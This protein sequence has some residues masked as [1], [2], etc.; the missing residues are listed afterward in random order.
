MADESK[1]GMFQNRRLILTI[2]VILVSAVVAW[3]EMHAWFVFRYQD[4]LQTQIDVSDTV[5]SGH[6]QWRAFQGRILIPA[7]I[8]FLQ[9]H[10]ANPATVLKL[11]YLA[12]LAILFAANLVL[13][14]FM[15]RL[16]A[17]FH[18]IVS[19][20]IFSSVF[21]ASNNNIFTYPW[22]FG[23]FILFSI[24]TSF[25]FKDRLN[26]V[27][28]A[29]FIVCLFN[30]ESSILFGFFIVAGCV[31]TYLWERKIE[32]R[33]LAIGLLMLVIAVVVTELLRRTLFA[34][35][36]ADTEHKL[37]ENHF[38]LVPNFHYFKEYYFRKNSSV[39]LTFMISVLLMYYAL[40]LGIARR[41]KNAVAAALTG[42]FLMLS[43]FV[44]AHV[45]E[46]RVYQSLAWVLPYFAAY[47]VYGSR[48]APGERRL[49]PAA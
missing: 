28:Y 13:C 18:F 34:D 46:S 6:P 23:E 2:G 25:F 33:K 4:S 39:L 27:F 5:M 14:F 44:V 26:W 19:T 40:T 41:D 42:L 15:M 11:I 32:Y 36:G 49:V 10:I 37:I 38:V 21:F 35:D 17:K 8:A 16:R 12:Y 22:D 45:E 43:I 7:A 20:L 48:D 30:R 24:M 29:A 9:D 47:I 31:V 1:R 3:I